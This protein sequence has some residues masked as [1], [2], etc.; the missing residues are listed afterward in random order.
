MV[1]SKLEAKSRNRFNWQ[2]NA[3]C[4]AHHEFQTSMLPLANG[5]SMAG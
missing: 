3:A 5:F 2:Y 4:Q 1:M